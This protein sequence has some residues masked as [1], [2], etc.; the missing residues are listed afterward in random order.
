MTLLVDD[1]FYHKNTLNSDLIE[2]IWHDEGRHDTAFNGWMLPS[3]A[4]S[5]AAIL[6]IHG[7]LF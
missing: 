2:I 7:I 6:H 4:A 5:F 3:L 1:L